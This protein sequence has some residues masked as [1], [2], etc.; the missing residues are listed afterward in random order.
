MAADL[1][2]RR[3]RYSQNTFFISVSESSR[4]RLVGVEIAGNQGLSEELDQNHRTMR[5]EECQLTEVWISD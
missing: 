2:S 5:F 3:D 1:T 4:L